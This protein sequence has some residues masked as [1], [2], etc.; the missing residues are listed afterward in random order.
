MKTFSCNVYCEFKN[1]LFAQTR[2]QMSNLRVLLVRH[3]VVGVQQTKQPTALLNTYL[4]Q[5]GLEPV[6]FD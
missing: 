1:V 3:Y 6:M 2:E 5:P 4:Y